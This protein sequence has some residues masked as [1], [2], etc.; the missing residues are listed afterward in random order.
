MAL[1]LLQIVKFSL[2]NNGF[3]IRW[4]GFFNV[5]NKWQLR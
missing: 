2:N 5:E 4:S 3:L 1:I